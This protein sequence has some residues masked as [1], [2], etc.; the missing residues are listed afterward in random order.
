MTDLERGI[1]RELRRAGVPVH[2][3]RRAAQRMA[4]D[5]Y[6]SAHVAAFESATD[7]LIEAEIRRR[8][9]RLGGDLQA[10]RAAHQGAAAGEAVALALLDVGRLFGSGLDRLQAHLNRRK[11]GGPAVQ[12][13]RPGNT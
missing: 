7:A 4:A 11:T 1:R 8:A 5:A 3:R 10:A 2:L 12:A 13:I 9:E 6:V